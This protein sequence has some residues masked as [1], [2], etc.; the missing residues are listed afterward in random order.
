MVVDIRA[1]AAKYYDFW[2]LPFDDIPFYKKRVPSSD[3]KVLELGCG[4]GR[5]LV[6]LAN[7]CGYIHGIDV[8]EVM[9]SICR[10]KLRKAGIPSNKAY[11]ETANITDFVLD[12]E[13]NLIIA[14]YRVFQNL[15]TDK[16]VEGF[17]KCV[18][19]HLDP[20]GFCILNVFKPWGLDKIRPEWSSEK[21]HFCWEVPC[22]SGKITCHERRRQ[23]NTSP[24]VLYPEAIYR[25]YEDNVLVDEAVLKI[26]MRCYYPEEFEKL[27]T[28]YGFEIINRWG[29]YA[30]EPYGEG[31]ELVIQFVD[32]ES[33]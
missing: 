19:R 15:E 30:K 26:V 32:G 24:L 9:L 27:I 21:E 2:P 16:E 12:R 3:A 10:E 6:P 5:V 4:T 14:P 11:V 20:D 8:S 22:Q 1:E 31:E 28:E 13:F 23:I 25:R 33:V 29:G 7:C 17:F 18:R